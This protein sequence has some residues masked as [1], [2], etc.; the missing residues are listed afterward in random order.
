[1]II[2]RERHNVSFRRYLQAAAPTHFHVRA[3]ELADER[4]VAL[5]HRDVEAIAVTV[6]DQHITGVADVD[7][8]REVRDILAADAPQELT[9][10]VE[11]DDAVALKHARV[12]LRCSGPA[13]CTGNVEMQWPCN[14]H[15]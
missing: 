5:E 2:L 14:M 4:A 3:L 12:M 7:P 15:E 9:I 13:T 1:M 8:V 6:T 10:L 11:D